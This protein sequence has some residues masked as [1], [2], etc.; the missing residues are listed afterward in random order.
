LVGQLVKQ[1]QL[2][3]LKLKNLIKKSFVDELGL[4]SCAVTNGQVLHGGQWAG[5]AR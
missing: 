3:C 5:V 4:G 2:W 1:Q